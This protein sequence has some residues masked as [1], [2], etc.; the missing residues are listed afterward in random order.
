MLDDDKGLR[1]AR[2][3][4][5]VRAAVP[6][7]VGNGKILHHELLRRVLDLRRDGDKPVGINRSPPESQIV[8]EQP[9]GGK[10]RDRVRC[11]GREHVVADGALDRSNHELRQQRCPVRRD[12]RHVVARRRGGVEDHLRRVLE[13]AG[14]L[15][16]AHPPR[17]G[18]VGVEQAES[19]RASGRV[20]DQPVVHRPV[21][22]RRGHV[23]ADEL[24]IR[25]EGRGLLAQEDAHDLSLRPIDA[26]LHPLGVSDVRDAV[27]VEVARGQR[28]DAVRL[29]VIAEVGSEDG[30]RR[31]QRRAERVVAQRVVGVVRR[32][33]RVDRAVADLVEED[34]D[35]AGTVRAG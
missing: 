14:N 2:H 8:K 19:L 23:R 15:V 22:E 6:V 35:G 32:V 24:R 27:P 12:G 1:A 31:L 33:D 4:H 26:H 11:R 20:V 7:G 10:M 28:R 34:A 25:V 13:E 16:S 30:H 17:R 18:G 21:D 9:R 5:H 3:R 29:G